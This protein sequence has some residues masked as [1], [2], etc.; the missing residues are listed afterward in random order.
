C[1]CNRWGQMSDPLT[2]RANLRGG[3]VYGFL[4][5]VFWILAMLA[6]VAVAIGFLMRR[7]ATA[8]APGHSGQPW[9]NA[10]P[11][12]TARSRPSILEPAPQDCP[13]CGAELPVSSPL[14]LCPQ[15]L[16]QCAMSHSDQPPESSEPGGT[17]A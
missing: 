13:V 6:V 5:L 7:R 1:F 16:F 15:C 8:Q 10:P 2:G 4:C 14:G 9:S 3:A 12:R 11:E 17:A